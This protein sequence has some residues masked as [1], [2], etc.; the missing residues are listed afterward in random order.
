[1]QYVQLTLTDS[2]VSLLA[3]ATGNAM[4][5]AEDQAEREQLAG[6]TDFLYAV[7][8]NPAAFPVKS[9]AMARAI[10]KRMSRLKG[11]AQPQRPNARKRTQLRSQG[12]QKRTRAQKR[13]EAAEWNVQR[14]AMEAALERAKTEREALEEVGPK[15][16][17]I[18][19][20]WRKN[21]S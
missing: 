15:N 19:V 11:P 7:E 2:Q 17:I 9:P 8:A 3:G 10:K 1:M 12:S 4:I 20:P 13:I 14:A 6:L 5:E 16:K 18:R 21:K